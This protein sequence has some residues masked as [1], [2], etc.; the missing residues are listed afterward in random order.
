M[1]YI[2]CGNTVSGHLTIKCLFLGLRRSI[3]GPSSWC[4]NE[5]DARVIMANQSNLSPRLR[6]RYIAKCHHDAATTGVLP[7]RGHQFHAEREVFIYLWENKA[8]MRYLV[9]LYLLE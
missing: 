6:G 7:P 1:K 9:F 8:E 5:G 3:G 2:A 4:G